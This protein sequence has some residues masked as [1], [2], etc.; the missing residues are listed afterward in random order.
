MSS[1]TQAQIKANFEHS[2]DE[3]H[4]M[5]CPVCGEKTIDFLDLR[6]YET[7]LE[8]C[9]DPNMESYPIRPT[10]CCENTK[11]ST[12]GKGYWSEGELSWYSFC[13]NDI[14]LIGDVS[15]TSVPD[16][17]RGRKYHSA[18][19]NARYTDAGVWVDNT[20]LYRFLVFKRRLRSRWSSITIRLRHG[21]DPAYNTHDH[22][23]KGRFRFALGVFLMDPFGKDLYD[24]I[25]KY[26][27]IMSVD[28]IHQWTR[29]P[30]PW[31]R[32]AARAYVD[33]EI[34]KPN[35]RPFLSD[36]TK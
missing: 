15:H 5:T 28:C 3:I 20:L 33:K 17:F 34:S 22:S 7:G 35:Y 12:Y 25:Y 14:R 10:L 29:H 2:W 31:V 21:C 23:L 4:D 32:K 19:D 13:K 8:H 1:L 24:Y 27:G 30:L 16:I 18:E 9:F 6:E 11:C 26:P 36:L